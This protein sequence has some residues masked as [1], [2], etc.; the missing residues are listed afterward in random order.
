MRGNKGREAVWAF[1][2]EMGAV[3]AGGR[4]P[5]DL[6]RDESELIVFK[7]WEL[8]C[9]DHLV[10]HVDDTALWASGIMNQISSQPGSSQFPSDYDPFDYERPVVQAPVGR[11]EAVEIIGDWFFWRFGNN[12]QAVREFLE[13]ERRRLKRERNRLAESNDSKDRERLVSMPR[14]D[15]PIPGRITLDTV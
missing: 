12:R 3:Q 10:H 9:T 13:K 5:Q 11:I 6:T 15:F 4:R 1:S 8:V 7:Y 14:S 2:R